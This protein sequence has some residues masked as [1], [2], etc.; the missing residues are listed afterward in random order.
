MNCTGSMHFDTAGV[1][2]NW[3]N[4]TAEAAC[5]RNNLA[6]TTEVFGEQ[7]NFSTEML[8]AEGSFWSSA[9]E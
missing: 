6:L 5:C 9:C 8:N 7:H 3:L 1:L 4:G 2:N